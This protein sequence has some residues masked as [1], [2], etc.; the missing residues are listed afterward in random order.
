[1]KTT[2]TPPPQPTPP[3]PAIDRKPNPG[4][5]SETLAVRTGLRAGPWV[6]S[7]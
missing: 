1:M 6:D 4:R 3:T 2:T 7:A 5:R